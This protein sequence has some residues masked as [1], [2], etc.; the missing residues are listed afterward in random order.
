MDQHTVYTILKEL[1]R[2][3]IIDFIPRKNIPLITYSQDRIDGC[4]LIITKEV[5]D[6]RKEEFA[7][8]IQAVIDYAS[9]DTIC[10]SRQLLRYFG[11]TDTKDCTH[12]DVCINRGSQPADDLQIATSKIRQLLSDGKRHS[13]DEL[14]AIDK[15]SAYTD[16]N[17]SNTTI[18]NA[19]K[20]LLSEEQAFMDGSFVYM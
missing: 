17:I 6:R 10:R 7:R 4:D 12:C 20:H 8:R 13:I 18:D 9:N 11:E 15:T 19:L 5:Y 1:S 14:Y 3:A 16:A 2:R